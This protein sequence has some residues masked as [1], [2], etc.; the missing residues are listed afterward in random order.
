MYL[1]S[2][3][4]LEKR[5]GRETD[6]KVREERSTGD[7][8]SRRRLTNLDEIF[9]RLLLKDSMALYGEGNGTPLQFSCLANPM[10]GGAW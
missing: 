8:I 6:H 4:T 5:Q 9:F 7:G 10:D 1:F 3:L 2:L